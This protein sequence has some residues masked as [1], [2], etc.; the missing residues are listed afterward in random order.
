MGPTLSE[1]WDPSLDTPAW[2]WASLPGAAE[3]QVQEIRA[4]LRKLPFLWCF[5]LPLWSGP[6]LGVGSRMAL[7]FYEPRYCWMCKRITDAASPHEPFFGFVSAEG[8]GGAAPGDEGYL[9]HLGAWGESPRGTFDTAVRSI[10]RFT[11][12]EVW[13]ED[14]P[15]APSAPPLSVG[16]VL[17]DPDCELHAHFQPSA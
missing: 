2:R 5:W 10:A 12:L 9:C 4:E 8:A 13:C 1:V 17:T 7:H 16:Y 6:I 11:L 3:A 15:G 14:V